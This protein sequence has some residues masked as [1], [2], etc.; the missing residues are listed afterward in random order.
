MISDSQGEGSFI[1][2]VLRNSRNCFFIQLGFAIAKLNDKIRVAG[3]YQSPTSV[4]F[5]DELSQ[6]INANL[7]DVDINF[8]NLT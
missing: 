7:A 3:S 5:R 4:P 8:I 6:R 2:N 1:D